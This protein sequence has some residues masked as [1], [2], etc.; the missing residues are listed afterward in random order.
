MQWVE[1]IHHVTVHVPLVASAVLAVVGT[2]WLKTNSEDVSPIVRWLGWGTF[3][4][5]TLAVI[6][7]ILAAPGGFGGDGPKVIADHRNLALTTYWAMGTAVI[8]FE[9]GHRIESLPT[10]RFGALVWWA[11][12]FG[13]IGTGHWGG[14]SLHSDVV[15]WDGSQ[16]AYERQHDATAEQ[17]E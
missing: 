8:A 14:S 9:W 3:I 5:T 16:P 6:S 4:V 2:Y 7:G 13:A 17:T 11:V 12:M 10:K 1:Y 15:P